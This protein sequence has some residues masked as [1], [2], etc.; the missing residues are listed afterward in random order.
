[1]KT[2]DRKALELD[3]RAWRIDTNNG[4]KPMNQ[5]AL[6]RTYRLAAKCGVTRRQVLAAIKGAKLPTPSA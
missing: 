6:L 4:E 5:D 2:D 1:M 3:I